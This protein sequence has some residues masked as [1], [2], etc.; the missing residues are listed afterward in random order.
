MSNRLQNTAKNA[1]Y[2]YI[3]QFTM[4]FIGLF[5]RFIFIKNLG[6]AYLGLNGLFS[7]VLAFL[8]FTELGVGAALGFALY[9]P[10][11]ENDI[12]GIKSIMA[13]QK[14]A[15]IFIGCA[16]SIIGVG[17]VPFLPYIINNT[18]GMQGIEKYFIITLFGSVFSYFFSY[19][20]VLFTPD[21]KAYKLTKLNL[22]TV[23]LIA[24]LQLIALYFTKN[25]TL[26]LLSDVGVRFI[27]TIIAVQLA[28][29]TYPFLQD[30]DIKPV[31]ENV[32]KDIV[33]NI[34]ALMMHKIG[35]LSV[36]YTDNML[37]NAFVNLEMVGIVSNY[38]MMMRY[39]FVLSGSA[40]SS[41]IPS[42]GN[43]VAKES[44]EAKVKFFKTFRLLSYWFFGWA[45]VGFLFLS[46]HL[47]LLVFGESFVL[48]SL[49][50]FFMSAQLSLNGESSAM[51]HYKI[52]SGLYYTDKYVSILDAL[53]NLSVSI[54]AAKFLGV[55][56][57]YLGT[58][59]YAV[60]SI[61]FRTKLIYKAAFL[62]QKSKLAKGSIKY[63]LFL[64]ISVV[65]CSIIISLYN[66]NTWLSFGYKLLVCVVLPNAVFYAIFG[67]SEE[68][69]YYIDLFK[70]ALN[71]IKKA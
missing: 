66:Y 61:I 50:V 24:I 64:I 7:E 42:I 1:L 59:T 15:N 8:S 9:K 37:I 2:S 29:K 68:F 63:A 49:C 16:M 36:N 33:T 71:S 53:V 28:K 38:T 69:R 52:A 58:L 22:I 4:M 18:T 23:V 65:C 30:K 19:K 45:S 41:A 27:S 14:K 10:I 51:N 43:L 60:F 34:K 55:S 47:I 17:L 40:L 54:I 44:L 21:Q 32:K 35:E 56:G 5:S 62:E 46:T 31:D 13:F 20:T 26:Y 6:T 48:P 25:Y 3:Y 12:E 67:K 11:A 39:V 70:K 57:V